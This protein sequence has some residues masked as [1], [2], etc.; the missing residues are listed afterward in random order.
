[1]NEKLFNQIAKK[2]QPAV[3]DI[4]HD[5]DGYW[6]E[7]DPK[8]EYILEGYYC[9]YSIHEDTMKE[10]KQVLRECL[11][12]V[13]RPPIEERSDDVSETIESKIKTKRLEMGL[14]RAEL[15]RQFNMPIRTLED[16]ESGKRKPAEW[17]EALILEK[18]DTWK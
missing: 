14:S 5:E 1:M 13:E 3:K 17:V 2:Y 7:L 9:D 8:G 4:Y 16:Y 6:L 15:A 11:V 12:K 18:M 10:V